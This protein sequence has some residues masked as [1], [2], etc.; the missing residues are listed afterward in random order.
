MELV[1]LRAIPIAYEKNAYYVNEK[2]LN[3]IKKT[4]YR[5]VQQGFYLSES[6]SLLNNKTLASLKKFIMKKAK[7]YVR[8]VLEIKDDIYI[9]QSWSTINTTNAFHKPHQ[10]PNT[11]ISLVYYAQCKDGS[12]FFDLDTTSIRECFNF[13]YTINKYNIYNS[14]NWAIPVQ[15]GDVVLFPGH[16]LHGSTPNRSPEPRIAIGTNFFIKGKLGSKE[17]VNLIEVHPLS[18]KT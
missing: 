4:K 18:L 1:N 3:V 7:E 10:H 2:E 14:Q 17:Y 5:P 9:T 6:I 12:I 15:T 8:D 11:F 13:Q 16:I